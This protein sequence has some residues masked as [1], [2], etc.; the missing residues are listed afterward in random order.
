MATNDIYDSKNKYEIFKRKID[1]LHIDPEE[2]ERGKQGRSIY[3][4]RNSKNLNYFG[5]LC[6]KFESQDISYIRRLRYLRTLLMITNY[7]VKDL[8]DLDRSD[9]D[10]LMASMHK[11]YKTPVSKTDFVKNIKRIWRI[12]F[13]ET[14]EKGRI[15]ESIC[16]YPVRHLSRKTDKSQQKRRNDKLTYEEY[17]KIVDYFSSDSRIQ[18]YIVF[19]IES[20]ARP[21]EMLYLKLKDVEQ[22]DNYAKIWISEHGKE[23]TGLLQCIDS[24]PYLVKWL[25][26]HPF[27]KDKDSFLFINTGNT[28]YGKQMT[29]FNISKRLKTGCKNLGIDKNVTAYSL[30]RIGVTFKRLG[31]DSD[32]EIQHT[33]RWTS[34][35]Q[36]KTYD[37]STQ[38]DALKVALAK[39]GLIQDEKYKKFQPDNKS[40][41]FCGEING[42]NEE[43]CKKCKRPLNREKIKEE[44]ENH[45]R[46]MDLMQKQLNQMQKRLQDQDKINQVIKNLSFL[47]PES[48]KP[49]L[50]I[51]DKLKVLEKQIADS[52]K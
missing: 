32:V 2:R 48:I 42:F 5:K 37:L 31:G 41:L 20:L 36:L 51:T 52:T 10:K 15:D 26:E 11:H 34:T 6:I 4:C 3:Y 13:P 27:K 19:A 25:Q 39:R 9:I 16:P 8:K 35:S 18:F 45:N 22:Y 49:L 7:T 47:N 17:E 28:N 12:L 21:Q 44:Y 43:I 1:K 23:G 30:K 38:E 29:P 14:D 46:G 33:A 24:Y 40:C 50:A